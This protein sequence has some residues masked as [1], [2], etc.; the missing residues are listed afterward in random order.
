M[1]QFYRY[2]HSIPADHVDVDYIFKQFRPF[3]ASE[4]RTKEHNRFIVSGL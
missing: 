1:I 2:A 4:V 3:P